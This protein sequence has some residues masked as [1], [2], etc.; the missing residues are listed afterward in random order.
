MVPDRG[1]GPEHLDGG[2]ELRE[3]PAALQRPPEERG[4]LRGLGG[5]L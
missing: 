2:R 4:R 1:A 3:D 5:W